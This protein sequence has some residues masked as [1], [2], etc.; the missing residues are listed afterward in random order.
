MVVF[1]PPDVPKIHTNSF[2]FIVRLTPLNAEIPSI[3]SK[4]VLCTFRKIIMLFESL[5][6]FLSASFFLK[7]TL[8][9]QYKKNKNLLNLKRNNT[10]FCSRSKFSMLKIAYPCFDSIFI[11]IPF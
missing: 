5:F 7:M 1:P 4:Y 6:L 8:V 11:K 9:V 2:S 3:P 10:K